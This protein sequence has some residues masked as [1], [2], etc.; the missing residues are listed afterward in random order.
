MRSQNLFKNSIYSKPNRIR[1]MLENNTNIIALD[2]HD[3]L[4]ASLISNAI[5]SDGLVNALWGSS[6]TFSAAN[7]RSD[8]EFVSLQERI[9]RYSEMISEFQ[10]VP[11]IIDGDNWS[12]RSNERLLVHGRGLFP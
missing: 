2:F 11:I 5:N 10:N 7:L 4:S 9:V 12:E 6:L 1:E 8:T 3:K